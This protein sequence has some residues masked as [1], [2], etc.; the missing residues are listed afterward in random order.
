MSQTAVMIRIDEM[1]HTEV[2]SYKPDYDDAIQ[3]CKDFGYEASDGDYDGDYI[4]FEYEWL[5]IGE[6]ES[7]TD[8]FFDD[9][10]L[11]S[12]YDSCDYEKKF[13]ELGYDVET[14]ETGSYEIE[15]VELKDECW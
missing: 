9:E 3:I 1:L 11:C 6:G 4:D 14:I 15:Y 12:L 5:E 7:G 13:E 8:N 2:Y 10:T